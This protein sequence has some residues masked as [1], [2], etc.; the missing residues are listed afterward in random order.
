MKL[1]TVK[2]CVKRIFDA[3]GAYNRAAAASAYAR[4]VMERGE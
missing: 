4:L 2:K 1:C 3:L